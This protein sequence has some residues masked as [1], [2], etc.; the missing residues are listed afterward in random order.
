MPIFF[1]NKNTPLSRNGPRN[2]NLVMG[3]YEKPITNIM[4]NCKRLEAS[5]IRSGI[6]QA[7]LCLPFLFNIIEEVL[8]REIGQENDI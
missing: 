7:F 1:N 3:I 2:S 4:F 5:L 8:P 6:R